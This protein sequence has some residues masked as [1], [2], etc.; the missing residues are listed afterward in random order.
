MKTSCHVEVTD[1]HTG[2]EP[3]R[4]ITKGYPPIHGHT[5]LEKRRYVREHLDQYRTLLMHEPRGHYDQYGALIVEVDE[6]TDA[7]IGV[8]FLHNEVRKNLFFADDPKLN[9]VVA[10]IESTF[11]SHPTLHSECL[12]GIISA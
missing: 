3:L 7:D 9:R 2:G 5:I 8:L 12:P 6:G 4:I 1:M 10:Y 11:Q